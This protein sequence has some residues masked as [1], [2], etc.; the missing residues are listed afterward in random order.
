[1]EWSLQEVNNGTEVTL[2]HNNVHD[3]KELGE[4]FSHKNFVEGWTILVKENLKNFVEK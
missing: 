3:F 4:E 1:M 2:V